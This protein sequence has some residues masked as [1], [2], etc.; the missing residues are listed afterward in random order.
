[1]KRRGK[2]FAHSTL[3]ISGAVAERIPLFRIFPQANEVL[4]ANL[5]FYRDKYGYSLRG[6]VI[7]PDHYHL[8]LSVRAGTSLPDLLRDFKSQV[9]RQILRGLRHSGKESLM[10]RFELSKP[11]KRNK[12]PHHRVLQHDNDVVEFF[13]RE[14]YLGKL[15]YMHD[16]PVKKGLA[17]H[18]Q[19]WP[20]S[21]WR[22][23]HTGEDGPIRIDKLGALEL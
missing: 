5:D 4:L 13:T 20:Y 16:N 23:Y 11:R 10:K 7:M 22:A 19:G 17:A 2:R 8:L 6:Y 9:G 14:I 3:F 18:P 1:M 15:R 21:S 12:D